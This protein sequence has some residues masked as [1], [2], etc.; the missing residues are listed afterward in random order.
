MEKKNYLKQFLIIGSGTLI[1]MIISVITTPILT[2]IMNPE[3][4]GLFS[5]FKTYSLIGVMVMSLGLDQSLVRFYYNENNIDYKRNL[6]RQCTF[7]PIIVTLLIS[8]GIIGLAFF[9]IINYGLC[10][11]IILCIYTFFQILN[12][13]S[14]LVVRLE[15]NAKTYSIL[16][17]LEKL[18]FLIFVILLLI[19]MKGREFIASSI[20]ITLSVALS[21]IFGIFF[22]KE[23]WNFKEIK[24]KKE[25]WN[26]NLLKYGLPFVLSNGIS[27]LFMAADKLS[28]NIYCSYSE[29]GVY[30]SAVNLVNIFAI[31]QQVFNTLWAPMSIEH[32]EKDNDDRVFYQKAN[33]YI[34]IIM[35]AFGFTVL[36][37]KDLFALILGNK[38]REAANILPFLIFNPIM[39]TISETTVQGIVFFKKSNLQVIIATI[40]CLLNF[41]GNFILIPLI[42][43]KGAAI[44]TG[45]SYIVFM[46]LRTIFSNKYYYIDFKLKKLF[47]ITIAAIAFC[48]YNTFFKFSFINIIFYCICMIILILVYKNSLLELWNISKKYIKQSFKK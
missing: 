17:I 16:R 13:M 32:Y 12:R 31:L 6:I 22:Q 20:A 34:T 15:Y 24:N 5:L 41:G 47:I 10:T 29:I 7:L 48:F 11:V 19:I 23:N 46:L 30:S 21:S 25:I 26:L 3:S 42:G 14:V 45:I 28:L 1:T 4:Y 27:E 8:M 43:C 39:Y 36:L 18:S 37:F 44:S 2:R 33:Q 35:F 38:Y 9:N 40:T